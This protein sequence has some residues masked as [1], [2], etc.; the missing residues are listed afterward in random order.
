MVDESLFH[1][2]SDLTPSWDL[3][4]QQENDD[5]NNELFQRENIEEEQSDDIQSSDTPHA[6]SR[7]AATSTQISTVL[8]DTD[9]SQILCTLGKVIY[10][11]QICI[12]KASASAIPFIS[13]R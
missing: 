5:V 1:F 3:F 11:F 9:L 6:F 4:L 8:T 12:L 2:R 7:Y 13:F 10:H